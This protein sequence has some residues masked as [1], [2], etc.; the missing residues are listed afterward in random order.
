MQSYLDAQTINAADISSQKSSVF[1]SKP[2]TNQ[3]KASMLYK[4]VLEMLVMIKY[5]EFIQFDG[6]SCWIFEHIYCY[7][8]VYIRMAARVLN[9]LGIAFKYTMVV[10]V[11]NQW[12]VSLDMIANDIVL[13][14]LIL[15]L[16]LTFR[17]SARI[18]TI[19]L[20]AISFD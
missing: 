6:L 8:T 16:N 3:A 1:V 2:G 14:R 10:D 17:S 5:V 13:Y 20:H 7:Q 15:F 19:L 11:L 18:S 9:E 4:H 12:N